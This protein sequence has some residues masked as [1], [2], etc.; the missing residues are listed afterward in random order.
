M[1]TAPKSPGQ[2]AYEAH[3]ALRPE[4]RPGQPR[5][6]WHELPDY[7]QKS[8]EPRIEEHAENRLEDFDNG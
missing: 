8:W 5:K 1:S 7:A 6:K 2:L 4:Y 3:V